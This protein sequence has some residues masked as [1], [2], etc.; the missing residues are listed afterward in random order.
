M[1]SGSHRHVPEEANRWGADCRDTVYMGSRTRLRWARLPKGAECGHCTSEAQADSSWYS[2]AA[3][4]FPHW[5][6]GSLSQPGVRALGAVLWGI[7][8]STL[9]LSFG[10]PMV[11]RYSSA[12]APEILF[13]GEKELPFFPIS[14]LNLILPIPEKESFGHIGFRP[15][16]S[17]GSSHF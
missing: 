9:F 14:V 5:A 13:E 8:Q 2:P 17:L 10:E 11:F 1:V 4:F 16:S 12:T 7:L 3:L 15:T 6:G